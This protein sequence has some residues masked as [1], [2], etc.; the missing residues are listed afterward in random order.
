V[1]NAWWSVQ[2]RSSTPMGSRRCP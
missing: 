2:R 1:L